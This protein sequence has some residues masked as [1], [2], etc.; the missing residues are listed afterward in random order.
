MRRNQFVTQTIFVL[1]LAVCSSR[2]LVGQTVYGIKSQPQGGDRRGTYYDDIEGQKEYDEKGTLT[3]LYQDPKLYLH[4]MT[5]LAHLPRGG[6]EMMTIGGNRYLVGGG[7][8]VDVTNPKNPV[9]INQRAPGGQVAYNQALQKWVVMR[10]DSCCNCCDQ[11]HVTGKK[12][13]PALNPPRGERL[14]VT[15]FDLTDPQNVVEI[16]HYQTPPGSTGTHGDG[17]YYDGGRYAYVATELPKTRGQPPFTI[18]GRILQVLDVSDLKNPKEASQWWVP[19]QMMTEETE[20]LK[21]PEADPNPKPWTPQT[22]F[23]WLTF[24][25]PCTV[26]KRVEEGGNRGYCAWGALGMRILDLSD[27]RQPKQVSA[28]DVS[29]PF[30]GGIPVHSAYPIPQRKLALISEEVT[31]W[32]CRDPIVPPF[33]VDLRAEKYPLTIATIPIPKPPPEAPY[34]DFCFRGGRFGTHNVHNIKGPGE[35]RIDL[36]GYTWFVGGFRLYDISNPFRPEEVAWIVPPLGKRRGVETALIEWD[37][38]II[39]ISTDSG[40]YI[41]SSP[42]LGEPVLGPLKPEHWNPEG[43]N[44]GAP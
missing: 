44:A 37:R 15:F 19:G 31:G 36:V 41:L 35:A 2:W 40:L 18:Q 10:S 17:N 11:D 9:I 43:F 4:N 23:N 12:P 13:H 24:H 39:H 1:I 7:V 30:D 34:N 6:G 14:G 16:G 21:W 32:D 28:V 8:I 5:V 20:Y 25:G 3:R 33:V 38:K 42:V 29:P 22:Q 27:I 26:P